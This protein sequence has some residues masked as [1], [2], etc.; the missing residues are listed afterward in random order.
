MVQIT[1]N[2]LLFDLDGTLV[3]STTA[4][5]KN[6]HQTVETHNSQF[7]DSPVDPLELLQTSHGSRSAETIKRYFPYKP[8]DTDSMVRFDSSILEK[9]GDLAHEING[10]LELISSLELEFPDKWAIVTS[11]TRD[12]AHGWLDKL[13]GKFS[14]PHV[15][16]TAN[17]VTNGKPHPEG[18]LAAFAKLIALEEESLGNATAVVFEDAPTGIKAGVAG[19]FQVIGIA[20]TFGKDTLVEAGA[21][22][23]IEDMLKVTLT[24]NGDLINITLDAI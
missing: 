22:I 17:D 11:G 8:V 2:Y 14:K 18:Y 24:K 16:I 6:W 20:S 10:S 21:T 4:V 23:V 13:F 1:T 12:L 7:P 9:Y 3:D 19:G 5:E 15:F